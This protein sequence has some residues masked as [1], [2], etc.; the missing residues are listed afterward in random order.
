MGQGEENEVTKKNAN[1][2][3]SNTFNGGAYTSVK[4]K[5]KKRKLIRTFNESKKKKNKKKK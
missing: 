5:G 1:I 3:V 4:Q 2:S